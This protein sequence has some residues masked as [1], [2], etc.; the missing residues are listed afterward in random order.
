MEIVEGEATAAHPAR[1]VIV[2]GAAAAD[3]QAGGD[4]LTISFGDEEQGR[5]LL[6]AYL[7]ILAV[8]LSDEPAKWEP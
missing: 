2:G 1:V 7:D 6:S 3:L 5:R 4:T 8:P